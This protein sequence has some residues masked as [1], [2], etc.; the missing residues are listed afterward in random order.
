MGKVQAIWLPLA[1]A[2]KEY[3]VAGH[4]H[5]VVMQQKCAGDDYPSAYIRVWELDPDRDR[6]IEL[7]PDWEKEEREIELS[8]TRIRDTIVFKTDEIVCTNVEKGHFHID[9]N[10]PMAF[11][12]LLNWMKQVGL[13][14][15]DVILTGDLA[16]WQG[17]LECRQIS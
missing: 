3:I 6:L 2:F 4:E 5:V 15:S 9:L 12:M 17:Q 8:Q 14:E 13:V 11:E 7:A 16:P 10:F 1:K